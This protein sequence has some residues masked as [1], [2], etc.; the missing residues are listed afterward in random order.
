MAIKNSCHGYNT[1]N[2]SRKLISV[3]FFFCWIEHRTQYYHYYQL[4]IQIKT[5]SFLQQYF[6][7]HFIKKL[8]KQRL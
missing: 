8:K 2:M 6:I 7:I 5:I 3:Y 1:T 4:L